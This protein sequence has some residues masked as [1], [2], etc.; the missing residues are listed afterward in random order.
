MAILGFIPRVA[1]AGFFITAGSILPFYLIFNFE[2]TIEIVNEA[3]VPPTP[4]EYLKLKT[5]GNDKL[6]KLANAIIKAESGYKP[7]AKNPKSSASGIFQFIDSTFKRFCIDE[8]KLTES[9]I[10]KNDFRIQIDCAII[11][12]ES[13][14]ESHWNAS[15]HIWQPKYVKPVSGSLIR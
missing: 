5:G 10:N 1:F 12:L 2:H 13:G 14:M 15:R 9:L 7:D 4:E 6:F 8:Y 3:P 11:M